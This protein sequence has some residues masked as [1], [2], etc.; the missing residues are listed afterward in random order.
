MDI[1][2]VIR[3]ID[4]GTRSHYLTSTLAGLAHQQIPPERIHVFP[5][6]PDVRWIDE[7]SR[8][9]CTLHVPARTYRATENMGIALSGAP[10]CDWVVHLEDDVQL[11]QDFLGSVSRWISTQVTDTYRLVSFFTPSMKGPM[12][13]AHQRRR[14]ALPFPL[15]RW[16]SGVAVALRWADAQACGRWILET[17]PV[18]RTGPEYPA[19]ATHRGA[20]KMI[21]AWQRVAYPSCPQ[22]LASVPC[23]VE[24]VGRVSSLSRLGTF[25]FVQAPVFSGRAWQP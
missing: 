10:A 19:W 11:C 16:T 1:Q 18:W 6:A 23:L 20:D 7:R 3:T 17:A 8:S 13:Q 14:S 15:E 22:A 24:H 4:R 9:R 12:K 2:L 25:P 21:A 5:T